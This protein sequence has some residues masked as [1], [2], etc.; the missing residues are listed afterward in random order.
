MDKLSLFC[1]HNGMTVN[2]KKSEYVLFNKPVLGDQLDVSISFN[3]E[4]MVF[5]LTFEYLG[6]LFEDDAGIKNAQKKE[7]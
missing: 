1:Q 7:C 6:M 4:N 3:G 2:I 5:K